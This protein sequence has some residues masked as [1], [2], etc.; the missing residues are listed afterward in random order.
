MLDGEGPVQATPFYYQF[1]HLGTPQELTAYSGEI[2]WSAK[3]WAYG[4]LAEIA[5]PLASFDVTVRAT[6]L[7]YSGIKGDGV[8]AFSAGTIALNKLNH[9]C[10][11]AGGRRCF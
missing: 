7:P 5:C 3:Y 9:R 6:R 11:V 4:N 1:D 2:M 8:S 10:G